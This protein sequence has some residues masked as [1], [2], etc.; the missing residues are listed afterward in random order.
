MSRQGRVIAKRSQAFRS[1]PRSIFLV[2][3]Q[4]IAKGSS[5]SPNVK[6]WSGSSTPTWRCIFQI[7]RRGAER[8][9]QLLGPRW[10]GRAG[11]RGKPQAKCSSRLTRRSVPLDSVSP[12]HHDF[13]R[14]LRAGARIP[15]ALRFS[16]RSRHVILI[17]VRSGHETRRPSFSAETIARRVEGSVA[18]GNSFPQ[19]A[20]S[21][22][23]WKNYRASIASH[24]FGSAAKLSLRL[25]RLV[26]RNA[27]QSLPL[28]GRRRPPRS[29]SIRISCYS[30]NW[31]R[32][33]SSNCADQRPEIGESQIQIRTA[34]AILRRGIG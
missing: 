26:P 30:D 5:F 11:P 19:R 28:P 6:P 34:S 27:R 33:G 23:H 29:T 20:G 12:R 13:R 15:G 21:S 18:A 31:E 16:G 3:T 1:G 8:T 32:E 14:L 2:G 7:F 17:T 24:I 9:F 22:A 25:S 4:M 10:Q